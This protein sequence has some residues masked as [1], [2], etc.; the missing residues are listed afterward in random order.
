MNRT[1]QIFLTAVLVLMSGVNGSRVFAAIPFLFTD[2]ACD[3]KLHQTLE[4]FQKD[5]AEKPFDM[6]A[7]IAGDPSWSKEGQNLYRY[8]CAGESVLIG[9]KVEAKRFVYFQENPFRFT[10]T[11][12]KITPV[13]IQLSKTEIRSVKNNLQQYVTQ[14]RMVPYYQ[15]GQNTGFK[16]LSVA[17]DSIF[18]KHGLQKYDVVRSLNGKTFDFTV[19]KTLDQILLSQKGHKIVIDRLGERVELTLSIGED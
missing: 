10:S 17:P 2:P 6:E 14:I 16:I 9:H 19:L 15:Q 12:Q 13:N 3:T 18:A 1:W 8:H 11:D 7:R 4:L 5:M